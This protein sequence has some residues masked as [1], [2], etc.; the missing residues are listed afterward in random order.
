MGT[1]RRY[2]DHP[3]ERRDA[4]ALES[5]KRG[6]P[7]SLTTSEVRATG[8]RTE[9]PAP[10]PVIATVKYRVIYEEPRTV[11]AEAI[12]WTRGAVLIR[13]A[14]PKAPGHHFVWVYAN[15]VRRRN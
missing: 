2:P 6:S 10:I 1:N 7:M 4:I 3:D 8:R 5:A 13:Y 12:A 14:D 11:E 15:A 9:P